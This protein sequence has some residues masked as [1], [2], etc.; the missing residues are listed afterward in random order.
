MPGQI[1]SGVLLDKSLQAAL[2][3]I[4][5]YNKPDFRFREELFAILMCNSWELL[6]KAKALL[7]QGELFDVLVATRTVKDETSGAD[8]VVPKTNRSGNVMTVGLGA[9]ATSMLNDKVVGLTPECVRNLDLLMEV[10]DNAVHLVA[11]DLALAKKI[12]EIGTATLKN[13]M[14][15]TT[16]W[17]GADFSRYNFYLMPLSFFHGF[18]TAQGLVIEPTTE[19]A[20]KFLTFMADAERE[21]ATAGSPHHVTLGIEIKV[22]KAKSGE[23]VPVRWSSDPSAPA[24]RVREEDVLERYPFDSADVAAKLRVRYSDFKMDKKYY[25]IKK[26]VESEN[27]YCRVRYLDPKNPRSGSKKF[28]SGE[29]FKVFD[30]HYQKK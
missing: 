26:A 23:G 15:L 5:I 3:A 14:Q 4:E 2:S 1:T 6:L 27:K 29:I 7:D 19:Q 13:Y 16:A 8:K 20:A 21:P 24:L 11:G 17:F 28:F 30:Q 10:R 22:V 9:L 18:E 12:L 25:K